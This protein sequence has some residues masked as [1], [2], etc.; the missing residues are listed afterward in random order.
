MT[1]AMRV[2]LICALLFAGIVGAQ[3]PQ[4]PEF[5]Y[6]G[7][8]QHNGAPAN[9]EFDLTFALFDAESGGN[10]VGATI[11]EP[12]F[13]VVDGLFTVS[14]AF[15]GAFVG[16][17]L[18]LEVSI[19][20][21]ILSPRK[22]ISTTPVAQFA[23]DGNPGP[24]GP[25]GPA[26]AQ[27]IPGA[28]GPAGPAGAQGL[29]GPPGEP[30]LQG[31]PGPA[32]AQG[33]QGLTG[34]PGPT[35]PEGPQGIQGLPGEQG[36]QGPPG[37][38]LLTPAAPVLDATGPGDIVDRF[39]ALLANMRVAGLL[40]PNG[41]FVVTDLPNGSE[42]VSYGASLTAEGG[43]PPY[44]WSISAGALPP[45]LDLNP[46]TG[47]VGGIPTTQGTFNFTVQATD[48]NAVV[49]TRPQ[50]IVI[51]PPPDAWAT[52]SPALTS[53]SGELRNADRRVVRVNGTGAYATALSSVPLSGKVY[54]EGIVSIQGAAT[55]ATAIGVWA[56][57]G[58]GAPANV[59]AGSNTTST[60]AFP[61][62]FQ[63]HNYYNGSIAPHD[64]LPI[65]AGTLPVFRFGIAVD[66][67][68]RQ[69]W[70]RQV[71]AKTS[72]IW[73]GGGDPALGTSPSRTIPGTG[74]LYAAG[75][76]A[77]ISEDAWVELISDPMLMWGEAPEGFTPGIPEP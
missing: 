41:L 15:P 20:G 9:G 29:Q 61:R 26:G 24:E 19:D 44:T 21:Q 68:T 60:G 16:D 11:A 47:A 53:S 50:Q 72:G 36:P 3:Q 23:L 54:F 27:G 59:Y 22:T 32:G 55:A 75:S 64:D 30:G 73:A 58:A 35:G 2:F 40:T 8:L 51:F 10:Q 38:S 57:E 42:S 17:Q 33:E 37:S 67:V 43:V 49:A 39:N 76:T 5:T 14:L 25:Q 7:R 62:E 28:T 34:P 1:V 52:F 45:D 13:P 63:W 66:V 12:D 56:H 70:L 71:T 74:I 46:A 6:Q 65:D 77:T 18:W 31:I 4:L 69:I 48:A